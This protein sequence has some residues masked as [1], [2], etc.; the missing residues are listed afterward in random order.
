MRQQFTDCLFSKS[1]GRVPDSLVHADKAGWLNWLNPLSGKVEKLIFVKS[2]A[3]AATG[4]DTTIYAVLSRWI[5]ALNVPGFPHG[6]EK[7]LKC[8]IGFE[9]LQKVLNLATIYIK[10]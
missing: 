1:V 5:S 8:E 7:E 2:Q 3:V 9:N 10:Y 4:D 6:I